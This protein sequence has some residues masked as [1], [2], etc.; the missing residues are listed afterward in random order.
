M[1]SCKNRF[2]YIERV[3]VIGLGVMGVPMAMHLHKADLLAA[4]YNRTRTKAEPSAK[5][6]VY[7]AESPADL[8][9]RVDVVVVMVSDGPD[10]EQ[11]LFGPGEWRRG[12][13][14][15][16]WWW[17]CL[18]TRLIGR[19]GSPRGLRNSAWSS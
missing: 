14:Q 2:I 3:G 16:S 7:V 19:G 12:R 11:V 13:G 8:A 1:V 17:T 6:G 18:P 15:A 5:L 4:V 9:R 10:V